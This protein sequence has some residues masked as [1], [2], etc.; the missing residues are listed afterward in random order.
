M[1]TIS[2]S[3]NMM[4]IQNTLLPI[5]KGSLQ[6][7]W[8]ATA[9]SKGFDIVA[10]VVDRLHLALRCHQCGALNKV[11]LFTLMNSQPNCSACI[12]QVWASDAAA[13]GLE[14]LSR[15]PKNRHYGLYRAACG[16]QLR[17]QFELIKRVAAL[18]TGVRCET[19]HAASEIGVA[20]AR[21]WHLLCPDP[22]GDQN[23]R[24][25]KHMDCGHEQRVARVNMQTGRFGC[26]GCSEDWVAAPSFLYA[27]SF[28]LSNGRELV[29][30]GF[31]RDP[32]SRLRYQLQRDMD[33]P[34]AILRQIPMATG[35]DAIR[36]EKRL[37]AKLLR[38]HADCVV[39]PASYRT[40]IRVKSEIYD[41]RLTKTILGHLDKIEVQAA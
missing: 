34:C 9:K 20:Q 14:F 1:N 39:D 16:H 15:D 13:A 30:L 22:E 6:P 5:H 33:M 10:R 19:C 8:I 27:M 24:L 11:R 7:H 2:H 28:T 3:Q 4:T 38:E 35:Q 17:R 23:Y 32:G 25:Y 41:A 26:G 40:Q 18:Q 37:H 29:K 12:E 21:G 31:S 36:L